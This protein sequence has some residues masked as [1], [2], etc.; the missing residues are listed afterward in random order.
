MEREVNMEIPY[1]ALSKQFVLVAF[2]TVF[3][4]T[5]WVTWR[6]DS[7]K[8]RFAALEDTDHG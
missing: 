4:L 7:E 3:L 5:A 1:L 6:S 8:H 2:T